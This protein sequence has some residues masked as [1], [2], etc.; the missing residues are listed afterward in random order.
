MIYYKEDSEKEKYDICNESCYVAVEEG[1]QGTKWKLV[2]HKV[3]RYLPFIPWMQQMYME[4]VTAKHMRFHKESACD[5]PD[6]VVHPFYG[7]AWKHTF[8]VLH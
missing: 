8:Q 3:I 7:E 4:P 5:N 2:P 1:Y 6:I